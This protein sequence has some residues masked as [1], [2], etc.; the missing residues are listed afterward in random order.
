[1]CLQDSHF[2]ICGICVYAFS[3]SPLFRCKSLVGGL[4]R[5]KFCSIRSD[6]LAVSASF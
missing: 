3:L 6:A 2:C 5:E 1:M 4:L